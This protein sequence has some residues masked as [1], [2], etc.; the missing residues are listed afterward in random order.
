MLV[1]LKKKS[2]EREHNLTPEKSLKELYDDSLFRYCYPEDF[3]FP[4]G[5]EG[6]LDRRPQVQRPRPWQFSFLQ[7][8]PRLFTQKCSFA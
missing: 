1:V 2:I 5:E 4:E 6:N 3:D 7:E 8:A